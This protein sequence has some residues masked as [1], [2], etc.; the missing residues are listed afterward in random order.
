MLGI[1]D[2]APDFSLPDQSGQSVGLADL[3]TDSRLILFFYPAD[4][5][6]V[7]TRE[8]CLF[9]DE[10]QALADA[11]IT[12]AGISPNDVGSHA[13]FHARHNLGY[14]LL[15]D[16]DK[17]TIRDYGVDGPFGIGIRRAT[18]GLGGLTLALGTLRGIGG[19]GGRATC[20]AA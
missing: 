17:H 9:R 12:V 7:C 15:A 18:F 10:H 1:G 14:R 20:S 2:T 13:R 8:V 4:F 19:R 16:P 11:G 3:L 5:T 6:P